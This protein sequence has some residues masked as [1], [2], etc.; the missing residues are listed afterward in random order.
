MRWRVGERN[1]DSEADREKVRRLRMMMMHLPLGFEAEEFKKV[2]VLPVVVI[3]IL[4]SSWFLFLSCFSHI[5]P[6]AD[7]VGNESL[8]VTGL[9]AL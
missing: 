6:E 9:L 5:L 7:S 3:S 8:P 1:G 2:E 4:V